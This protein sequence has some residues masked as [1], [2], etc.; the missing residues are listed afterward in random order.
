VQDARRP[1]DG[2]GS[3]R[4]IKAALLPALV[5]FVVTGLLSPLYSTDEFKPGLTLWQAVVLWPIGALLLGFPAGL[6]G[7]LVRD[8][9]VF[10]IGQ[11]VLVVV[12]VVAMS[13]TARSDDAQA[14][15]IFLIIPWF[16]TPAVLCLIL[17]QWFLRRRQY[18]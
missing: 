4:G 3:G 5:A 15:L 16:G 13:A 6:L 8:K 9:R 10:R 12:A 17:A 2:S 1:G 14:G 7:V 11:V 18:R